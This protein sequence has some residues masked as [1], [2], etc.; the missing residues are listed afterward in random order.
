MKK[1][2]K[3]KGSG[4]KRNLEDSALSIVAQLC[5]LLCNTTT[6]D[7][8]ARLLNKLVERDHEKVDRCVELFG[9]YSRLLA[10]TEQQ[11]GMCC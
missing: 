1:A 5:S 7:Y 3:R 2:L 10:H 8:P 11:I 4:E 9:K 6:N